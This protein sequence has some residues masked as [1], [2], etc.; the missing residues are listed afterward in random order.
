MYNYILYLLWGIHLM[1]F[2][3]VYMFR[4]NHLGLGDLVRSS[5]LNKTDYPSLD[6]LQL[7][8]WGENSPTHTGLLAGAVIIEVLFRQTYC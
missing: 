2:L 1:L 7:F 3:S 4:T 6:F 8:S 5:S